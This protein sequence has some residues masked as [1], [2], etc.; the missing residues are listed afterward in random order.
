[1][2]ECALVMFR[3]SFFKG[4]SAVDGVPCV[5]IMKCIFHIFIHVTSAFKLL[6]LRC[7]FT[8]EVT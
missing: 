5:F 3:N 8:Y 1:V 6:N 7:L 2:N 4:K